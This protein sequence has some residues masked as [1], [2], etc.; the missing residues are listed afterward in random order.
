MR[1]SLRVCKW[2]PV[3]P[4]K[5]YYEQG[6]ISE[7]WIQQYCQGDWENCI[8]YHMEEIGKPHPDYMLP[9]GSIDN[10]LR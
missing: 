5:R 9:D 8:R 4:M 7:E 6:K 3:C 1:R 10:S 2:F